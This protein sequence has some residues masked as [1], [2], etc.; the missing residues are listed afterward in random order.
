[1]G[2]YG[3]ASE[4]DDLPAFC[5]MISSAVAASLCNDRLW[6]S[7]FLPSRYQ[8]VKFPVG[9]RSRLV[10]LESARLLRK[11]PA[12]LSGRSGPAEQN[13]G[14]EFGDPETSARVAQ[15][16]MAFRMQF[17]CRT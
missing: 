17:P 15:Y 12:R 10:P 7:A 2:L 13:H 9:R 5:V 4:T 11:E 8:G 6:G 14:D 1:M 3:L 16:E